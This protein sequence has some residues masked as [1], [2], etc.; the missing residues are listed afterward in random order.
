MEL[1]NHLREFYGF[2][3]ASL[4]Q[5]VGVSRGHLSMAAIGRKDLQTAAFLK[6]SKL[7]LAVKKEGEPDLEKIKASHR[8]FLKDKEDGFVNY[9]ILETQHRLT[10]CQRKLR[11]MQI[12][13]RQAIHALACL[14]VLQANPEDPDIDHYKIME[15][16]TR[17]V[18]D[19]NSEVA[20]LDL[21]LRIAG[22]EAT[23]EF[24]RQ[25]VAARE[26]LPAVK[27]NPGDANRD[28]LRS[29]KI[30]AGVQLDNKREVAQVDLTPKGESLE[31]NP[32]SL[33]GRLTVEGSLTAIPANPECTGSACPDSLGRH[34]K[35][36]C[37]SCD[38]NHGTELM[39][40]AA[41]RRLDKKSE[42]TPFDLELQTTG[43]TNRADFS[44]SKIRKGSSWG[45]EGGEAHHQR[46]G[47]TNCPTEYQALLT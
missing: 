43:L 12:K 6:L 14:A 11:R 28:Q 30:F 37:V 1:I 10:G 33:P 19:K 4:A 3:Q 36:K 38:T 46:R 18:L 44:R 13:H 42:V 41:R 32:T 7:A 29:M 8:S 40:I 20:Q 5:Y 27:A 21:E 9:K 31:A 26:S 22:L 25:R 47:K 39:G 17:K 2:P 34:T 35:R 24:L 15:M 45:H 16:S 23:A